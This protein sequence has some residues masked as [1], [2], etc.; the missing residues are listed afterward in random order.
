[1][2]ILKCAKPFKKVI[3]DIYI[4]N[5]NDDHIVT[6]DSVVGNKII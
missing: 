1:M 2:E 4:R 3:I 6:F 5:I